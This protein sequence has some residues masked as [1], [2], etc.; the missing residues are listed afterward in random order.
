MYGLASYVRETQL[1]QVDP[2]ASSTNESNAAFPCKNEGAANGE[3]LSCTQQQRFA[4]L[5]FCDKEVLGR[6]TK[7]G[8]NNRDKSINVD[9]IVVTVVILGPIPSN[10]FCRPENERDTRPHIQ[11]MFHVD[12]AS[13]AVYHV[14]ITPSHTH[15][16]L[17]AIVVIL[18]VRH[19]PP[20]AAP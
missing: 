10:A 15:P 9:I 13:S 11:P 4:Q 5:N 8:T 7:Q 1:N 2:N 20:H 14:K 3:N 19:D 12:Q 16:R 6:E 17:L 18:V